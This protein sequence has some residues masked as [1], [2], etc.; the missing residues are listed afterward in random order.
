MPDPFINQAMN[1]FGV[2]QTNTVDGQPKVTS[3]FPY[4]KYTWDVTVTLDAPVT[5]EARPADTTITAKTVELPRWTIDSQVINAYNHKTVVQTK[6]NFEPITMTFYD[7]QDDAFEKLLWDFV[8]GQF[9]P[10]DGAKR[11]HFQPMTIKIRM[12]KLH[13]GA[14]D[15]DEDAKIYILTNAFMVDAQHDTLDYSASDPILWT[16]TFRYENIQVYGGGTG[17]AGTADTTTTINTGQ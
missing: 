16:C 8:K 4:L 6:L 3:I 15:S 13:K 12:H 10:I 7:Q 5:G 11:R 9:D 1:K 17:I 14:M 2:L